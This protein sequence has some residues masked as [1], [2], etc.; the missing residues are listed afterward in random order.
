MKL[1]STATLL[2]FTTGCMRTVNMSDQ[3]LKPFAG[4]YAVERSKYGFTPIPTAGSVS[5]EGSSRFG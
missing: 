5:I 2:L 1:S 3:A 4:M